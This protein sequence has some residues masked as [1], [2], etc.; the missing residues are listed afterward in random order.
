MGEANQVD[1]IDWLKMEHSILPRPIVGLTSV[2]SLTT[3]SINFT[4]P[5]Y[6][7]S[8]FLYLLEMPENLWFPDVFRGYGNRILD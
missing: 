6:P 5:F 2:R 4:N 1:P 7:N 8:P 3:A